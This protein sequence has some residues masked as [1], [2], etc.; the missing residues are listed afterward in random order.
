M[1]VGPSVIIV[2][3]GVFGCAAA[4]FL[5]REHGI[6]ATVLERDSSYRCASSTLSASSIRQ[7]FST[8]INIQLSQ[9]SFAFYRRIGDELRVGDERPDIGL[10]ERGYLYLATAE[11]VAALRANHA[12]QR[13]HHAAVEWLDASAL[14]ARFPW[15]DVHDLAAGTLG[16][17]GEGW[18]DGYSV[19]Q[20]FRRKAASLGARFVEGDVRTVRRTAARVQVDY[21]A[22]AGEVCTL[23]A[24]KLLIAAGAW[25]APLAAQC[26]FD[27]PVRARKRD[28]F[29]F[30][31]PAALAQCPLVI[32]PSGVW[33]RPEGRAYICGAP[34]RSA[35]IDDAPLDAI[36][37]GL[38]DEIIWPHLAARVPAFA[39]L[40]VTRAWAGYYEYN[41]FDQNGL[42]GR[43][44]GT[45][46]VF[47]ACG[48]S[49]HGIQQAPAVGRAIAELM[50]LGAYRSLDLAA[51]APERIVRNAPLR[52]RNV[53]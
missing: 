25:S 3:G 1:S 33:F 8:P 47:A 48:F 20:A 49:G 38:F 30:T 39:A 22:P 15:L 6:C 19:L 24:E 28:V 44:P 26:G 34:P 2:G 21:V 35:D 9:Q 18:F 37:H 53:I 29:V 36:D 50:A 32:D 14:A 40:R 43:L 42:V 10:I 11:G 17:A 41:T 27:L 16:S 51:L 12:T 13:A 45:D 31:S 7:Q 23:S 5:A 4:F 46:H 52:E